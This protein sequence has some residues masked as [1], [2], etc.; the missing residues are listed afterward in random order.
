M[1]EQLLICR[2][3]AVARSHRDRSTVQHGDK[4]LSNKTFTPVPTKVLLYRFYD[5]SNDTIGV[6]FLLTILSGSGAPIIIIVD[7]QEYGSG[8]LR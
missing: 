2:T 6:H 5:M 1:S 4:Q 8:H 3:V 7:S